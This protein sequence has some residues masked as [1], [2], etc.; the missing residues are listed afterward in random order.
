M[1]GSYA[2]FLDSISSDATK[3]GYSDSIKRYCRYHKIENPDMLLM[4][5]DP[6]II[7]KHIVEYIMFL[8]GSRVAHSTIKFLVAPI[9]AFYDLHEI[10]LNRKTIVKFYGEH[11]RIVKDRGYSIE[12]IGTALQTANVRMRMILLILAS[13]GCRIGSLPS[14][15][16]S[17]LTFIPD[18]GLYKM[19]LYEST[20]SEHYA[21][22]T[23]ECAAAITDYFNFRKR[24]GEKIAFNESTNRWE[25]EDAPFI[26]LA[27]DIH[28]TLA[29]RHPKRIE[30]D[31]IRSA[32]HYHLVKCGLRVVEHP[33]EGAPSR[34]RKSVSLANGF[35][36]FTISSFVRAGVKAEVRQMLVDHKGGYL[37]EHY[38]RLTQEEMLAEY[39]KAEPYLTIDPTMRLQQEVQTLKVEK[40]KWELLENKMKEYDRV[41]GLG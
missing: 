8:R 2:H 39:L 14:L 37:D 32:L 35:R 34:V 30:L 17:N 10:P 29:A 21:F 4:E 31:G 20:D 15:N 19:V 6:K 9:F 23:R 12:E 38:V 1:T 41:L 27:F 13:V 33:T 36:K 5:Q 25:P 11:I 3:K 7:K 22:T 24:C 28:D 16:L 26:R 18:Y 40:T